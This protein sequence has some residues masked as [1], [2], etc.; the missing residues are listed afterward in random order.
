MKVEVYLKE[1]LNDE[2]LI[3]GY[4]VFVDEPQE[5]DAILINYWNSEILK[6]RDRIL[7]D[8]LKTPA[9]FKLNLSDIIVQRIND[10]LENWLVKK[11]FIKLTHSSVI[12]SYVYEDDI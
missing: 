4:E 6:I 10:F 5:S 1:I 2:H 11:D 9:K 8:V 12:A 3:T 7:S